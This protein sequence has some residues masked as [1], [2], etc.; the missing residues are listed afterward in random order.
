MP[1]FGSN[2]IDTVFEGKDH[3]KKEELLFSFFY[4]NVSLFQNKTSFRN[5]LILSKHLQNRFL[6]QN[7]Y[8][9]D[10]L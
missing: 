5:H 9:V 10:F 1:S 3:I 8:Q 7:P 6:F 2:L 4:L